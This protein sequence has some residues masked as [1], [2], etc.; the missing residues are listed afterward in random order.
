MPELARGRVLIQNWHVF[1]PH[2][3]RTDRIPGEADTKKD[4][5]ARA[6]DKDLTAATYFFL[7]G[8]D[9]IGSGGTVWSNL[10]GDLAPSRRR[11]RR[12]IRLRLIG[13][14][15]VLDADTIEH[16]VQS[17]LARG[18]DVDLETF[19][20]K[21]HDAIETRSGGLR[22]GIFEARGPDDRPAAPV[23]AARPTTPPPTDSRPGTVRSPM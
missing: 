2:N 11:R 9:R 6:Y 19:G 14:A 5:L 13:G 7:R 12:W 17:Q 10:F 21:R 8:D 3:V 18:V 15:L 16:G 4:G 20:R 22:G 1:E 23:R